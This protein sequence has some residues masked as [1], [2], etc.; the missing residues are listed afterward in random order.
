MQIKLSIKSMS[1]IFG[2]VKNILKWRMTMKLLSLIFIIGC[3]WISAY[4]TPN[5]TPTNQNITSKPPATG[6]TSWET[7]YC[8]T[9]QELTKSDLI[10][11]VGEKWKSYGES[12]A[13]AISN[14][15]GAQWVGINIGKIICLYDSKESFDFPIALEPVKTMLVSEPKGINWSVNIKGYKICHSTNVNDC[16]FVVQKPKV[17]KSIYEE[18][19]YQPSTSANKNGINL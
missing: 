4:A 15:T 1:Y 10:W 19:K 7:S 9:A 18:I 6:D 8:P 5:S 12:F 14:F 16:S 17:I 13:T 2:M 11:K 3:I